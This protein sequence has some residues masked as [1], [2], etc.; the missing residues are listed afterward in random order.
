VEGRADELT[1]S[2]HELHAI[3]N[4]VQKMTTVLSGMSL[5]TNSFEQVVRKLNR[6]MLLIWFLRCFGFPL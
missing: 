5:T 4:L 6:R 3:E 1:P 2:E